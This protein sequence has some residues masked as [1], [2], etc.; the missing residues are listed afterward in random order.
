MYA[1]PSK[2]RRYCRD[3]MKIF[4]F[5]LN[6]LIVVSLQVPDSGLFGDDEISGQ[7]DKYAM[8]DNPG[9]GG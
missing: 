3:L 1:S 6:H 5:N 4:G 9:A 7:A 2:I 8:L